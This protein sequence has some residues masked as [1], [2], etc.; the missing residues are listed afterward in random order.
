[1]TRW[2]RREGGLVGSVNSDV[3]GVLSVFC[4]VGVL[5]VGWLAGGVIYLDMKSSSSS[6]LVMESVV[7]VV[8][9]VVGS[10]VSLFMM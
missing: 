2:Y 1:M 5:L 9:S 8:G 7:R 4:F 10:V 6:V 3:G